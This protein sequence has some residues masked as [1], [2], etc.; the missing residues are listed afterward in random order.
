MGI[1]IMPPLYKMVIVPPEV[2]IVDIYPDAHPESVS[3]DGYVWHFFGAGLSWADLVAAEGAG[4]TDDATVIGCFTFQGA[5][6]ENLWISLT[7][8]IFL[9]Y[10]SSLTGNAKIISAT[11]SLFGDSKLDELGA[12]PDVNI[13]SS[14]P[15]S[16][17]LL[18]RGDYNSLGSTPFCDTPIAYG[19]WDVAGYNDF[20]LNAAGIAAIN[21]TGVTKLGTRNVNY[22]VAGIAPNWVST[23][24]RSN[25]ICVSA[26][27]DADKRPKLTITYKI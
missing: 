16:N 17:T 7:R 5:I 24:K 14:A 1:H 6:D 4:S 8:G 22:D 20:I 15:L 3:V 11:L 12:A 23:H 26:E 25:V 27:G 10:T 21:K 18:W 2:V 13:Y 19:D 9:F